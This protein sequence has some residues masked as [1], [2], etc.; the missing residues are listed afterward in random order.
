VPRG[1]KDWVRAAICATLHKADVLGNDLVVRTEG[2]VCRLGCTTWAGEAPGATF[3]VG[4]ASENKN[5]MR[6]KE[7]SRQWEENLFLPGG[8]DRYGLGLRPSRDSVRS[9]RS[10]L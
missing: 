10:G 2:P 1:R 6:P 7:R 5:A 8:L 3:E 4:R 9:G